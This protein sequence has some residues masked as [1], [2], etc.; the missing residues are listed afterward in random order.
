M[1]I[2][3]ALFFTLIAF[4]SVAQVTYQKNYQDINNLLLYSAIESTHGGYLF[5]GYNF[6]GPGG[7]VNTY[8]VKTDSFGNHHWAKIY[9]STQQQGDA[10]YDITN[11]KD[12]GYIV[13]G[14]CNDSNTSNVC[15][16]KMDDAGAIQWSK[17]YG[18]VVGISWGRN[19]RQTTDGGYIVLGDAAGGSNGIANN[20][21]YLIKTDSIGNIEWTKTYNTSG[22]WGNFIEETQNKG[23][24]IGGYSL[25]ANPSVARGFLMSV[26]STGNPE[27][28]KSYGGNISL[29]IGRHVQTTNGAH[30]FGGTYGNGNTYAPFILKTDS[31]YNPI[32]AKQYNNTPDDV[33]NA[34][35]ELN[36]HDYILMGETPVAPFNSDAMII[37][38]DSAGNLKWAKKTGMNRRDYAVYAKQLADTGYVLLGYSSDSI[39]GA[40]FS[41]IKTDSLGNTCLSNMITPSV[42]NLPITVDTFSFNIGSIDTTRSVTFVATSSGY[43]TLICSSL[44]TNIATTQKSNGRL[45][46]F[47]NPTTGLVTFQATEKITLIEIT[48]ATGVTVYRRNG[49]ANQLSIYLENVST[50]IYFYKV[51][52]GRDD[53]LYG[54]LIVR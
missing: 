25:Y 51:R 17:M 49:N 5:A 42:T 11:T 7:Y 36:D 21:L 41:F 35:I 43:D 9:T 26:D 1:K 38:T 30:I 19:V 52:T 15:L 12:G 37:K 29:S 54:K 53:T 6:I 39:T 34:L 32:W 45:S 14:F 23:Y 46:V 16:L 13:T 18:S 44:N 33:F 3:T 8:I 28:V 22:D 47:P 20:G 10:A 31:L 24:L 48:D 50:G 40:N 4:A 27:W 2:V